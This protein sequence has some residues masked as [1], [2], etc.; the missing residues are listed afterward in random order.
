MDFTNLG[1]HIREGDE[2]EFDGLGDNKMNLFFPK[3]KDSIYSIYFCTEILM[4]SVNVMH[5]P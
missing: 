1:Y 2:F 3:V 4:G 5:L